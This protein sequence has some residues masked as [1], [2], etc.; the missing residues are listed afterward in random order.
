MF[1][2]KCGQKL[3]EDAVFCS[4]CGSKI[5]R[6]TASNANNE[7]IMHLK[8]GSCGGTMTVDADRPVLT[9]P[10]CG[11][12]DLINESDNVTIQRVKSKA[13]RDVQLGQQQT[14]KEIELAKLQAELEK[15]KKDLKK[16]KNDSSASVKM[17]LAFFGMC[18]LIVWIILRNA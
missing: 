1:C 13:Y 7:K 9:C 3:P 11:A 15:A 8:C 6:F 14:T 5:G 16:A 17:I 4:K 2:M 10:Y 12:S 18:A